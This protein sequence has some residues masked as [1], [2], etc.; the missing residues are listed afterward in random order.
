MSL[1]CYYY[2][3]GKSFEVSEL[4]INMPKKANTF[5]LLY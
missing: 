2:S 4:T 1:M 3:N 5:N